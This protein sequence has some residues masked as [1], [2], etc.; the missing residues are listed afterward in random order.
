ML[1]FAEARAMQWALTPALS[2][3]ERECWSGTIGAVVDAPDLRVAYGPDPN[4]FAD[5]RLPPGPGPHPVLVVVHGGYYRARYDL[6]YLGSFCAD[7]TGRGWATWNVEYRRLGQPGGGWP[8]TF[9][10]VAAAADHLP[11]LAADHP[12]DLTRV[13]A[14]GHSAG[15]HLALWLA[16]RPRVAPASP[17]HAASPLPIGTAVSLAGVVD[18]RRAA[19]LRLSNA[20]VQDLLGGTPADVPNRYAAASPYDLLPLGPAVRQ[21]LIHG[22]ADTAVP[23]ELSERYAARATALGD[24]A[25]LVYLP[26][27]DHFA[28]VDPLSDVWPR[29]VAA[30]G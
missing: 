18:L 10:D 13:A 27:V 29:V 1:G 24:D 23:H 5:L 2:H 26:G 8:G 19:E 12:L 11:V 15:G 21:V 16:A 3:R 22:T 14:L 4:Q 30:L 6:E 7:L 17:L 25:H 20:V 9:L 28:V